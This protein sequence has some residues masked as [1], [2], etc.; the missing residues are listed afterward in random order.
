MELETKAIVVSGRC[1]N[2][3]NPALYA[4]QL[5]KLEGGVGG[6]DVPVGQWT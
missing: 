6:V 5:L 2:Y 3:Y 4:C 1:P